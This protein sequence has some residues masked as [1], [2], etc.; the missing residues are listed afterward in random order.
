[1]EPPMGWGLLHL[2]ASEAVPDEEYSASVIPDARW[3][4]DNGLREDRG[5]ILCLR[6]T[7]DEMHDQRALDILESRAAQ[8][9]AGIQLRGHRG[10]HPVV[11]V[12]V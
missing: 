7:R 9:Q 5:K 11:C 10:H 2:V 6:R 1:M 12:E 3:F 4:S 8:P